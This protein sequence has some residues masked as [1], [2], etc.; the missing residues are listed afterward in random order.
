MNMYA[1]GYEV[2]NHPFFTLI[3]LH[4]IG[5]KRKLINFNSYSISIYIQNPYFSWP[6]I[7]L[8]PLSATRNFVLCSHEPLLKLGVPWVKKGCGTLIYLT[9]L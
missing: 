1:V 2:Y 3:G 9:T 7:V 4:G 6:C 8:Y 5:Y